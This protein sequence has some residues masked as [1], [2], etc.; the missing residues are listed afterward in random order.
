MILMARNR[1]FC[2]NWPIQRSR[3]E[4]E[5]TLKKI[6]FLFIVFNVFKL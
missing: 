6:H 1:N 3:G 4:K 5:E 2:T